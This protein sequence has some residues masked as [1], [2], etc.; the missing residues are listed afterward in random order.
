MR[1][2]LL[3]LTGALLAS[4][5]MSSLPQ[6]TADK[7][8]VFLTRDGCVNTPLMRANLDEALRSLN[9]PADYVVIDLDTVPRTDHRVAYPTPTLLYQDRDVFGMPEPAPASD[10]AT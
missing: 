9:L 2:A 1:V 7:A 4:A 5:C 8:L 6:E 10:P 3:A